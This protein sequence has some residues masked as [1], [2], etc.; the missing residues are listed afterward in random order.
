MFSINCSQKQMKLISIRIDLTE[1]LIQKL[2]TGKSSAK[3][4]LSDQ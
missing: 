4:L 3:N 1:M 2:D